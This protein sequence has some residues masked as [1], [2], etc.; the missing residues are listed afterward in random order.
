MSDQ[1]RQSRQIIRYERHV[2]GFN[3]GIAACC[4]HGHPDGRS[5]HR[6]RVV[7]TV[8][9]HR[10]EREATGPDPRQQRPCPPQ[11]LRMHFVDADVASDALRCRLVT[12]AQPGFRSS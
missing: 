5:A 2:R 1:P 6:G 7:D 12:A 11:E 9:D 4:T 10:H 8:T 3:G